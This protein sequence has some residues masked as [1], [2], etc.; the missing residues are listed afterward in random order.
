M[1]NRVLTIKNMLKVMGQWLSW[2]KSNEKQLLG[3]LNS[4]AKK[5]VETSETLVGLFENFE[6]QKII[7]TR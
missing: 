7:T 4:L 3:I 1:E 2:V 5:A 6:K